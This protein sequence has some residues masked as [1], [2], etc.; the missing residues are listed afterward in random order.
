[1]SERRLVQAECPRPETVIAEA[2]GFGTQRSSDE[3]I[4]LH[5]TGAQ[6]VSRT[7]ARRRRAA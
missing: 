2:V 6:I 3:V 5:S 1:M 4:R 7:G